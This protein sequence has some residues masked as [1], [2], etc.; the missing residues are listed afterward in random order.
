MSERASLPGEDE[1]RAFLL[2]FIQ[3]AQRTEPVAVP[4][5][6]R[7][8]F[9]VLFGLIQRV[10]RLA[11]AYLQ[12][13]RSGHVSEGTL[14]VRSAL[15]HAATAQ[16]A[17]LTP[18]GIGRLQVKLAQAQADLANHVSDSSSEGV[19]WAKTAQR[20]TVA[21]PLGPGLPPVSGKDGIL[22][23]L[24]ED[25]FL[26]VSYRVLSQVGHVTH[27]APLDFITNVNGELQLRF[28]PEM[29]EQ[30]H[31]LYALT[32]FCMLS[33]WL[34]A[35]LE[36]DDRELRALRELGARLRV[37]WRLDTHLPRERRRFPD[38]VD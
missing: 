17:Y 16:W 10:R 37:P 36:H 20:A 9:V 27:R 18:G 25:S 7:L 31:I 14:L 35:R 6:N 4:P 29:R 15:E 11:Q 22:K 30:Q 8:D 1:M 24:D 34:L 19:E 3:G 23:E 33:A 5:A 21:I 26:V 2:R 32:G 28:E 13:E 12:L 38:E